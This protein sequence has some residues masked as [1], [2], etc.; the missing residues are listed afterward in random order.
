MKKSLA[1]LFTLIC[2]CASAVFAATVDLFSAKAAEYSY[3]TEK[4]TDIV[5]FITDLDL[6]TDE[7]IT[8]D[9]KKF[10]LN[11]PWYESWLQTT[12]GIEFA[13][14]SA[15]AWAQSAS[16]TGGSAAVDVYIGSMQALLYKNTS[17]ALAARVY[18]KKSDSD[19]TY[20]EHVLSANFD[21]TKEHVYRFARMKNTGSAGGYK[22]KIYVDGKEVL[23]QDAAIDMWYS[24]H[25]N[26]SVYVYNN[27]GASITFK[28][29][30]NKTYTFANEQSMD[31]MAFTGDF[32]YTD[33]VAV[34][35]GNNI[36]NVEWLQQNYLTNT[37]GITFEM[38]SSATWSGYNLM[39]FYMGT[40]DIR[41]NMP[42]KNNLQIEVRNRGGSFRGGIVS[43]NIAFDPTVNNT[44]T[45]LKT[46]GT[47][48]SGAAVR[49]YI[50]GDCVVNVYDPAVMANGSTC[51]NFTVKNN[52]GTR[53]TIKSTFDNTPTFE[54]EGKF[55]GLSDLGV[56]MGVMD[57]NDLICTGFPVGAISEENFA[58]SGL[59]FSVKADRAWHNTA[60]TTWNA[61]RIRFGSMDLRVNL[62]KDGTVFLSVYNWVNGEAFGLPNLGNAFAFDPTVWHEIKIAKAAETS[63]NGAA[64]RMYVDGEKKAEFYTGFAVTNNSDLVFK[65]NTSASLVFATDASAESY[66]FS[67]Q[68]YDDVMVFT[69][70]YDYLSGVEVPTGTT[71]VNV[72][73][74]NAKYL[75]DAPG[76]TF[77]M[78]ADGT[79]SGEG[80]MYFYLGATEL[81]FD[82]PSENKL[83][84]VVKNQI[85][86]ASAVVSEIDFDPTQKNTLTIA[87]TKGQNVD[88]SAVYVY[89][90]EE[91]VASVYD[92][93]EMANGTYHTFSVEN[94]SGTT[95][96]ITSTMEAPTFE[97]ETETLGLHEVGADVGV[98]SKNGKPYLRYL[99]VVSGATLTD[100]EFQ[101]SGVRFSIK[102]VDSWY[103]ATAKIW[104]AL[105]V[106]F[107]TLQL[108][109]NC[110][111][112]GTV[113]FSAYNWVNG[114]AFGVT[115]VGVKLAF[116][117]TVWHDIEVLTVASTDGAGASMRMY[118]DGQ[119]VVDFYTPFEVMN[120]G[121]SVVNNGLATV[122]FRS[123]E[124]GDVA[125]EEEKYEDIFY[126][127]GD[128]DV[129]SENG[130]IV[131]VNTNAVTVDNDP[132]F[133]SQT[134]GIEFTMRSTDKWGYDGNSV[135]VRLGAD[136]IY[137][138][139]KKP[140]DQFAGALHIQLNNWIS[141]TEESNW[142]PTYYG[143][144][145]VVNKFDERMEH[146]Y[147]FTRSLVKGGNGAGYVLRV[148]IDGVK[149][150]GYYVPDG[151]LSGVASDP[152]RYWDNCVYVVNN[153]D[154][155][156]T[157]K[158]CDIVIKSCSGL[159]REDFIFETEKSEDIADWLNDPNY[160]T[161]KTFVNH[162]D[163]KYWGTDA[164]TRIDRVINYV[165][166]EENNSVTGGLTFKISSAEAWKRNP[167]DSWA[168]TYQI[169]LND[170]GMITEED[171]LADGYYDWR[172]DYSLHL[173]FGTTTVKFKYAAN[174]SLIARVST[175]AKSD[176]GGVS[177]YEGTRFVDAVLS[178]NYD[179]TKEHTFKITRTQSVNQSGYLIRIYLD[180]ME[181]P[182]FEAFATVSLGTE[183]WAHCIMDNLTGTDVTVKSVYDW[184]TRRNVYLSQFENYKQDA[185]Y[186][187]NWAK[188]QEY[189]ELATAQINACVTFDELKRLGEDVLAKLNAV[190]T[191]ETE[192]LFE[193]TKETAKASLDS[194]LTGEYNAEEQTQ[195]NAIVAAGKTKLE[196]VSSFEL[197]EKYTAEIKVRL[198]DVLTK[199][200]ADARD[201]AIMQSSSELTT[202]FNGLKQSE[203]SAQSWEAIQA[204]RTETQA[205]ID[206][207]RTAAE[208][209]DFLVLATSR[210][211]Q[212]KTTALENAVSAALS[213]LENYVDLGKY[214]Q[215]NAERI[216]KL[217]DEGKTELQNAVTEADV[218]DALKN[219]KAEIDNIRAEKEAKSGCASSTIDGV[220]TV[221]AICALVESSL[222]R[223]KKRIKERE[224]ER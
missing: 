87:K 106:C 213:E 189:I 24:G 157:A 222:L 2:F 193:A 223:R 55:V 218:A 165:F 205:F 112:D 59:S 224:D 125:F 200:E 126:F 81:R 17:G 32:A 88:G 144:F 180:D 145:G 154:M 188:A 20:T 29:A 51:H 185:Y 85:S 115:D 111:T 221:M 146:T 192:E 10:A 153:T 98:M 27:T 14:K 23:T 147:R 139:K 196:S 122:Y 96:T 220:L 91:A 155:N 6:T 133:T 134:N 41:F 52:T 86:T 162:R 64:I 130:L 110:N 77:S 170:D 38:Q 123:G 182:K 13:A 71:F 101:R 156:G 57:G 31:V 143:E 202:F 142:T 219:V 26:N 148:Y 18:L 67:S 201:A 47:S 97:E 149:V 129:L 124:L 217:M 215:K 16:W 54:E 186:A 45:V 211:A 212:I 136:D 169:D 116:D 22:L 99:P 69:G 119:R 181:T 62:N 21:E 190:W 172:S 44:V 75:S 73:W 104:S 178:E 90:N 70:N 128:F 46:K 204:V 183:N 206:G 164:N 94:M 103:H 43:S 160:V 135:V 79:W 4:V 40:T 214:N 137:L 63:G 117:S 72:E 210:V 199:A 74:I 159:T 151:Y 109:M 166:E 56:G 30:S 141:S 28:S 168:Y 92:A 48:V 175:A 5:D 108:D 138:V 36:V 127:G 100:E 216:Q 60:A 150:F 39:Y 65:N 49:V 114:E 1:I 37:P 152:D 76:I 42:S 161:G 203:Y 33:G 66:V 25:N 191:K 176:N 8:V 15:S 173:A 163:D 121:V 132:A 93:A 107:G 105:R 12:D 194:Y 171:K 78:Q 174:G 102:A 3:E 208:A 140:K 184:Q 120:T 158:G 80:K 7:G 68:R 61:L 118:I 198:D 179:S 84:I 50:N 167:E 187:E 83:Q 195:I 177:E 82:M 95:L 58:K 89:I 35:T 11:R 9:D 131:P 19:F 209:N 207:A 197:L 53:L 34:E 113:F